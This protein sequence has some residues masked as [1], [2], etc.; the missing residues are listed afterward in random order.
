M[1]Q[2][3]NIELERPLMNSAQTV[4]VATDL[5]PHAEWAARRGALLAR[6]GRQLELIHVEEDLARGR[7]SQDPDSSD[8]SAI[9]TACS[10]EVS[11]ELA[12]L[13][14]ELRTAYGVEAR[15]VIRRGR[16]VREIADA[17]LG[18]ELLVLGAA[19]QHPWRDMFIGSTA[20]RL[21]RKAPCQMLVVKR[22]PRAPYRQVI[23]PVD[24]EGTQRADLQAVLDA[25]LKLAPDAKCRVFHAVDIP[26]EGKMFVAGVPASDIQHH[27][28]RVLA[29]ARSQLDE[30]VGS[31]PGARSRCMVQVGVGDPGRLLCEQASAVEAD[32]I[33][34]FKKNDSFLEEMFLGSVTRHAL[35]HAACD[36][37]VLPRKAIA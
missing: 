10:E 34:M 28:E 17:A 16:P 20:D 7:S 26:F 27:R 21:L 35:F 24:I 5:S 2:H 37:L 1:P 19:G 14:A 31:V 36:V 6:Q 22:S 23:L 11:R 3:M 4:L 30:L 33:V 18:S 25:S 32:L 15:T 13:T 29:R 12:A 8:E 9:W